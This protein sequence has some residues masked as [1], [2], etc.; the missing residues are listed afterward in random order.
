MLIYAGIDEAG[1]GPMLGP[2]CV[3]CSAFV[4]RDHDP[5]AGAPDVWG[6]VG[7]TVCRAGEDRSGRVAIDD[8]KK[9]KGANGGAVHPLKR[10][11]RGVLATM[12]AAANGALLESDE[13][14]LHALGAVAPS[15][16]WYEGVTPLP[17]ANDADML[18]ID[19]ARLNRA[20]AGAAVEPALF[21]AEIIDAGEFNEQLGRFRNKATINF[22]AAMRLVDRV[23]RRWPGGHPRIIID[24]HGGRT[25]YR[26]PLQDTFPGAHIAIVAEED[27]FSR[28]RLERDGSML[29]ITFTAEGES[30]HLPVALASMIAKYTRELLMAR[31]NR[32]FRSRVPELKP[33]AGYVQD[34]RRFVREIGPVVRSLRIDTNDLVRQA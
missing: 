31:L 20:L 3:A 14:L 7:S 26:E 25:H 27:A 32:F 28:Y 24:R 1:Y 29:T 16:P 10:L 19:A 21:A 15:R 18:R 17:A 4:L 34:G 2:L 6:M 13:R 30:K 33:T 9:L 8:S 23:W 22:A 11:E 12:A 5:A